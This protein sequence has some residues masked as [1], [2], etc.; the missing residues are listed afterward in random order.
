MFACVCMEKGISNMLLCLDQDFQHKKK[1]TKSKRLNKTLILNM[2]YKYH[3]F[4]ISFYKTNTALASFV[5]RK[6]PERVTN[7]SSSQNS[8]STKNFSS[9]EKLPILGLKPEIHKKYL[10][11]LFIQE[12]KDIIKDYMDHE[13]GLRVN[14]KKLTGQRRSE[15]YEE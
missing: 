5:H 15:Y 7:P 9:L 12:I 2:N 3:K 14:V 4:L 6:H 10:E 1:N 8:L 13:E 11:Q